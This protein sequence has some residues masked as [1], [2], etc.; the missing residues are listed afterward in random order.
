[1]STPPPVTEPCAI[2]ETT[3][4]VDVAAALESIGE[5]EL[6]THLLDE[7]ARGATPIPIASPAEASP[8]AAPGAAPAVSPAPALAIPSSAQP[9][10]SGGTP[11]P[12]QRFLPSRYTGGEGREDLADPEL[13]RAV[14]I[15]AR[16]AGFEVIRPLGRGAMGAVFLAAETALG[17]QVALKLLPRNLSQRPDYLDRFRQEAENAASLLHENI[18]QVFSFHE[19]GGLPFFAMEY[20][21]GR[22]LEELVRAQGPFAAQKALHVILEAARGLREIHRRGLVHRDIKP[23][24]ILLTV[25]GRVKV[26]DFGIAIRDQDLRRGAGDGVIAGTPTYMSPEA[27]RGERVTPASDLCSLALTLQFLITARPP[28][29][30]DGHLAVLKRVRDAHYDPPKPPRDARWPDG[31]LEFIR[32]ATQRIP[33]H[34]FMNTDHFVGELESLLLRIRKPARER[35][36]EAARRWWRMA[37]GAAACVAVGVGIGLLIAPPPGS[38]SRDDVRRQAAPATQFVL[39]RLEEIRRETPSEPGPQIAQSLLAQAYEDKDSAALWNAMATAWWEREG[40]HLRREA[41]LV[42]S[43]AAVDSNLLSQHRRDVEIAIK[44][45]DRAAFS[46]ALAHWRQTFS[47]PAR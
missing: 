2:P 6:A 41:T 34:R 32:R 24:N 20:V 10:R 22:S 9:R 30:G 17:R 43:L 27:A 33:A 21:E 29:T 14:A 18:V 11:P 42:Q 44:S 26:A 13:L 36:A 31:L 45:R 47:P 16:P 28:V 46:Q 1:M 8:G 7:A 12:G 40:A 38:V 19:R 4:R 39:D 37:L 3:L 23:A 5:T 25:E 35:M 15:L